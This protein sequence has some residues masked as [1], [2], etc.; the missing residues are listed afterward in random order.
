[1][2]SIPRIKF[3]EQYGEILSKYT[4]PITFLEIGLD[5]GNSLR[6]W[7]LFFP[8]GSKFYG[9]DITLK[10]INADLT[11][12]NVYEMDSTDESKMNTI[13]KDVW[14]DVIVD[15]GGPEAH[16]KTFENFSKK[17]KTGGTYLMETFRKPCAYEIYGKLIGFNDF[18][19]GYRRTVADCFLVFTKL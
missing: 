1:M 15:D 18:Q 17:L 5:T 4:S 9:I 12:F 7:Q 14:F 11:G 10:N 3:K 16:I 8:T 13:F 6:G 2:D 19:I